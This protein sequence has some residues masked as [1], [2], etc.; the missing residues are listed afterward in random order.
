MTDFAA[1]ESPIAPVPLFPVEQPGERPA[2][3]AKWSEDYR[4]RSFVAWLAKN[5][6]EVIVFSITNEGARG[7][8]HGK[9]LKQ[10]GLLPGA[11]DI[12]VLWNGGW[13]FVEFKGWAANGTPG[14]LSVQQIETC[15]RI[16][17]N[18]TPVAVFYRAD[19]AL[20]W[21]RSVGCPL[22]GGANGV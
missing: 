19:K 3:K 4:Q 11:P 17:K 10:R 22:S 15:N 12:C 20:E 2:D 21:L 14:K 9:R 7:V 16:H 1:L 6:P 13:A 18:G 5:H 8:F